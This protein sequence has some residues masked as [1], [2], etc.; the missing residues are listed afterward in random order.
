[1][2]LPAASL[3]LPFPS[4]PTYFFTPILNPFTLIPQ[5]LPQYRLAIPS[6]NKST[7]TLNSIELTAFPNKLFFPRKKTVQDKY[8][9]YQNSIK[10]IT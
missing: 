5:P 7:L 9:I 8:W 1:M 3:P 2:V 6:T 4:Y 10:K